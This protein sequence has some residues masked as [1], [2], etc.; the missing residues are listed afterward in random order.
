MNG[1]EIRKTAE[2]DVTTHNLFQ[3]LFLLTTLQR[4]VFKITPETLY[5]LSMDPW[6]GRYYPLRQM[7]YSVVEITIVI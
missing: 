1:V 5:G 4:K 2:K 6:F 7:N 3:V